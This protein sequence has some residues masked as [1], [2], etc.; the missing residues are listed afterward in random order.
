[1]STQEEIEQAKKDQARMN[2]D[3]IDISSEESKKEKR[4]KIV[5][6]VFTSFILM[7]NK[8]ALFLMV[9]WIQNGIL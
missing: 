9:F 7:S 8:G 2:A 3:K 5:K 4:R 1:L 6:R